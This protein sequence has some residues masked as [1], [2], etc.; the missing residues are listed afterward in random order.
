MC[1]F[2]SGTIDISF[3]DP[4]V[5]GRNVFSVTND[6]LSGIAEYIQGVLCAILDVILETVEGTVF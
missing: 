1:L 3:I 5:V 4:V 6:F 2:F